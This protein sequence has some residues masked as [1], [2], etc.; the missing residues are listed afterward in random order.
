[1]ASLLLTADLHLT[2]KLQDEARWSVFDDLRRLVRPGDRIAIL[3]DLTDEKDRHDSILVNR[4]IKELESLE[5]ETGAHPI[6]LC[7]NHDYALAGKP[8]FRFI[9]GF[10]AKPRVL[11]VAGLS[12]FLLPHVDH[13]AV[14]W[15]KF[16]KRD[17]DAVFIH[18]AIEGA[19]EISAGKGITPKELRRLFS[20]PIFAGDVHRPQQPAEGITYV[21]A[22]YPIRFG[23]HWEPR[24][25]RLT[26]TSSGLQV[27]SIARPKVVKKVKMRVSSL[28]EYRQALKGLASGDQARVVFT[29]ESERASRWPKIKRKVDRLAKKAGVE[30]FGV[31]LLVHKTEAEKEKAQSLSRRSPADLVRQYGEMK[32]I[33][34]FIIT[35]GLEFVHASD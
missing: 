27:K 6:V 26:K 33:D 4:I 25:L 24:F 12:V 1:M 14:E 34:P 35:K 32:G 29:I 13:P 11:E 18:Q 8:F 23:D 5:K 16:P 19:D 9:P 7:G 20:A 31:E 30:V 15:A 3:G 22:P 17:Y 10:I 21:G 28:A 2:S